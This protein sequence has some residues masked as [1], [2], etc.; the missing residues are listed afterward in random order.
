MFVQIKP[1]DLRASCARLRRTGSLAKLGGLISRLTNNCVIVSFRNLVTSNHTR[2]FFFRDHD[3]EPAAMGGHA[4]VPR[5]RQD[6]EH[7]HH[8]RHREPP[9]SVRSGRIRGQPLILGGLVRRVPPTGRGRVAGGPP[10]PA[11]EP[12]AAQQ[13]DRCRAARRCPVPERARASGGLCRVLGATQPGRQPVSAL[14]RGLHLRHRS[15]SLEQVPSPAGA[16]RRRHRRLPHEQPDEPGRLQ[17][18]LRIQRR[19]RSLAA[20]ESARAAQATVG[21]ELRASSS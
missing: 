11:Q 19:V 15:V 21:S 12:E 7:G 18:N 8:R 17:A 9:I 5:G 10:E 1:F 13:P 20:R 4:V 16:R 3:V 14:L 6:R 2:T